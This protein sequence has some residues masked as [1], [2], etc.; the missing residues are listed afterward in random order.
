MISLGIGSVISD[1]NVGEVSDADGGKYM[2]E[3]K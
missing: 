2:T 1:F 3:G